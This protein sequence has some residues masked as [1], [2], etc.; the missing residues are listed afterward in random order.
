MI[1]EMDDRAFAD[2]LARIWERHGWQTEVT[3]RDGDFLVAGD[4]QDGRRGLILVSPGGDPVGEGPVQELRGMA[5]QKGIDVPVAAT[6]SS[7]EAAAR[8]VA[9]DADLHLLDPETLE[10]T[11]EAQ[12]FEDLLQQY[13]SDGGPGLLNR[14][15][16]PNLSRLPRPGV[17]RLRGVL[18]GGNGLL[19]GV[20]GVVILVLA[21]SFLGLGDVLGGLLAALPIPDLGLLDAIGGL[22]GGLPGLGGN[23]FSVTAVSLMETD[24]DPVTVSWD[25]T[26]GDEI[27]GPNG[28]TYEAPE[29]HTFVLVA[30]NATNPTAEAVV[31]EEADLGF[32]AGGGRYGPQPLTGAE[33]QVPLIVPPATNARG[34]V[35]FAVPDSA[36][37][38]TLLGLPGPA[39]TPLQ[40]ERARGLEA[41]VTVA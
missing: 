23:G 32:A 8:D 36:T 38:G 41:Q 22:L 16:S 18:A 19:L 24:G 37:E 5:E 27:A 21:S 29:N 12:G 39:A 34:F 35:V 17:G 40:F 33:G 3:A 20:V 28:T 2:L 7:F 1:Q 31:I 15:P 14:L 9:E 30:I 10:R 4:R 13:S 25:A 26:R 6:R 11:A